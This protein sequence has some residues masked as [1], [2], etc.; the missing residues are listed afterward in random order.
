MRMPRSPGQRPTCTAPSGTGCRSVSWSW[1]ATT[2]ASG[3][4]GRRRRL[5]GPSSRQQHVGECGL[6]VRLG[7][8]TELAQQLGQLLV[9][10]AVRR[11][12]RLEVTLDLQCL[13]QPADLA[14]TAGYGP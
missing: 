10:V 2:A 4:G 8:V 3:G 11:A 9:D 5:S 12:V 14:Q 6:F 1:T 7:G 13:I